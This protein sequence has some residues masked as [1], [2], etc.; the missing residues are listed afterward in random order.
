MQAPLFPESPFL[1]PKFRLHARLLLKEFL[2]NLTIST[3]VP[4]SITCIEASDMEARCFI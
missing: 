1:A 3:V 4:L 2:R